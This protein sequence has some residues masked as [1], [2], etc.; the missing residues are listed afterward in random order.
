MTIAT[1]KWVVLLAGTV[2]MNQWAI[3]TFAQS[4]DAKPPASTAAKPQS[5]M[6]LEEVVVT[7]L[8]Q[9]LQSSLEI[10]RDTMEVV[11]SISAQD[12]GKLPD[13]NVA[14]ALSRIPGVQLYRYAGEGSAP[15]GQGNGVTIR[16][17]QG[18]T[19]SEYNGRTYF[20]AGQREYSLDNALPELVS[21]L[22]VYKNPS[23]DHIEG[24]IGGLVNIRTA[25]PFDYEGKTIV[26]AAKANYYDF[27]EGVEPTGFAMFSDRWET[28]G[29]GELGF[30]IAGGY[31][32][33]NFRQDAINVGGWDP[34]SAVATTRPGYVGQPGVQDLVGGASG[35]SA[36]STPGDFLMTH[37]E[38]GGR[39]RYG[40]NAALQW[41]P[42]DAV[43]LYADA[44][45]NYYE[46]DQP[47][48]FLQPNSGGRPV[49]NLVTQANPKFGTV[50]NAN[51][52]L[53]SGQEFVSGTF[54]GLTNM[55]AIGG[56]SWT[57]YQTGQ[58]A[59]G[60]KW[61]ASDA[62]ELST[63]IAYIKAEQVKNERSLTSTARQGLSWDL[64]KDFSGDIPQI[65]ISG[66]SLADPANWFFNTTN[67]YRHQTEDDGMAVRF[68]AKYELDTPLKAL[69]AGVRYA[70]QT[71]T[72]NRSNNTYAIRGPGGAN[73]LIYLSS[74][75][76]FV[77]TS[78]SNFF[79]SD[80]GFG[81][82]HAVT[83]FERL[84]GSNIAGTF[85]NAYRVYG[86]NI[87]TSQVRPD[88]NIIWAPLD[89]LET[90]EKTY[91]GYITGDFEFDVGLP[92]RG[93]A[94]VRFVRTEAEASANQLPPGQ[95]VGDY[96][97][98]TNVVL[99]T[100]STSYDNVLPS[101]NLT[102]ELTDELLLRFGY[103][104]GM[105][106]SSLASL[107]PRININEANLPTGE[108]HSA[109]NPE[110]GP[111]KADSY[112]LSLEYYFSASGYTYATIFRK[113][114]EGFVNN[115]STLEDVPGR[116]VQ[117]LISR[118]VNGLSGKIE[119]AEVG[120]Q[121][122]LSFLPGVFSHFGVQ[123][124]Y[125][126]I[127]GTNDVDIDGRPTVVN[128]VNVPL[129]YQSKNSYNLVG[130]YEDELLTARL[131]YG[132]RSSYAR[133]VNGGGNP[134][135]P[136]ETPGYGTLD[137]S[138]SVNLS[139]QLSVNFDAANLT[140]TAPDRYSGDGTR[141]VYTYD[142]RYGIGVRYRY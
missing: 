122:F 41:Q 121:S 31:Q 34:R 51:R 22:D 79:R 129:E 95:T 100:R 117:Y 2:S 47:Y 112:D 105:S 54:L 142:R 141:L 119:G 50:F 35:D 86:G 8:R 140:N 102:A 24:A 78:D 37:N 16:G 109:G 99:V 53:V 92:I 1:R 103:S 33:S 88:G 90:V 136:L 72:F 83:D 139:D 81:G 43:E 15:F 70:D 113:D 101:L 36:I 110:L 108:G 89:Y 48:M 3:P 63:D 132:Y 4:E 61:Q 127:D 98:T 126:Y 133:A 93:N 77:T 45:Y 42:N 125:T 17:L 106:R 87:A 131:A 56:R 62:L 85:P 20:T 123:A 40:L 28:A 30:L 71:S 57:E 80:A 44:D 60:G 64:T 84:M 94:G 128:I 23:A 66:P 138:V 52:N 9:S 18:Q 67:L 96:Q 130:F 7:G 114:V 111:Q 21:G 134:S 82:G 137:A 65:T 11:D 69:R 58:V 76:G 104:K 5:S 14:D 29:G 6:E 107:N 13:P 75:P 10:K 73:D 25:R 120:F 49:T 26:G 38:H 91:A 19:R 55:N 68:D 27:D 118:P 46:Y 59:I 124:N 116:S 74:V 135:Y 32:K 97:T 12:I 39:T 115:V